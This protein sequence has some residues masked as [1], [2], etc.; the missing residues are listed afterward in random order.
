MHPF[1][2]VLFL[3]PSLTPTSHLPTSLPLQETS[4]WSRARAWKKVAHMPTWRLF[5][6]LWLTWEY[7]CISCFAVFHGNTL[8]QNKHELQWRFSFLQGIFSLAW[9][10]AQGTL[11]L[12]IEREAA[13]AGSREGILSESLSFFSTSEGSVNAQVNTATCL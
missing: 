2:G 3:P 9:A 1:I 12:Q 8:S 5:P 7:R 6:Q 4:D 11:P 10:P 13:W